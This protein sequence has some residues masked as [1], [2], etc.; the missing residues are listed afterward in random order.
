MLAGHA[1]PPVELGQVRQDARHRPVGGECH[2]LV[3]TPGRPSVDADAGLSQDV[4]A[5]DV[6]HNAAS[7]PCADEQPALLE[8]AD[9]G[10]HLV[11]RPFELVREPSHHPL[12]R[13][14]YRLQGGNE[15][16]Q[17]RAAWP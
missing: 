7:A 9:P 16:E 17:A 13:H 12:T 6:G 15:H 8:T 11:R 4:V 3:G 10:A 2:K 14:L 5:E 1:Q